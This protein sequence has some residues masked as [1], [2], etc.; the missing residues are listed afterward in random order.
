MNG[1]DVLKQ[2]DNFCIFFS[3]KDKKPHCGIYNV[4]PEKCKD[5]PFARRCT[6]GANPVMEASDKFSL[7]KKKLEQDTG[8]Y[9]T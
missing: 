9:R 2:K 5:F 7:L 1:K 6:L 8:T 4:R 3:L